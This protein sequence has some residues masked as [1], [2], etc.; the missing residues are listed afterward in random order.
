MSLQVNAQISPAEEAEVADLLKTEERRQQAMLSGDVKSLASLL[1]EN[2]VYIH[3]SSVV[4]DEKS[5]LVPLES[6]TVRYE[7][8]DITISKIVR[9]GPGVILLS[10]RGVMQT[11][12]FGE[13]RPLDN[14]FIMTWV[15]YPDGWRMSS[16]QSTPVVAHRG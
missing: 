11:V 5:Y 8:I 10:G 15:K 14:F 16:W 6:K 12:Q 3:S 2:A 4:D 9:L 13:S 1:A 7:A